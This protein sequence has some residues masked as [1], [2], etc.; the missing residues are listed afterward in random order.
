VDAEEESIVHVDPNAATPEFAAMRSEIRTLLAPVVEINVMVHDPAT[1][2]QNCAQDPT[3]LESRT[4]E[5]LAA[6]NGR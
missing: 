6:E 4:D 3:K 5:S 2:T 1:E